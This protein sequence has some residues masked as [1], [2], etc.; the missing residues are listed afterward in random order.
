MI[1]R[2]LRKKKKYLYFLETNLLK[3]KFFLILIDSWDIFP[4]FKLYLQKKIYHMQILTTNLPFDSIL[5]IDSYFLNSSKTISLT[6]K[7]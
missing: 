1:F 3:I 6:T 2:K 4:I 5:I 7:Q